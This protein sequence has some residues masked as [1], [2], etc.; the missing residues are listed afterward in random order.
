MSFL[1]GLSQGISQGMLQQKRQSDQEFQQQQERILNAAHDV[2][3]NMRPED[4]GAY[5]ESLDGIIKAKNPKQLH[6]AF[7]A[8]TT[9]IIPEN[10]GKEQQ[11]QDY[12]ESIN[13]APYDTLGDNLGP[14][15][16]GGPQLVLPPNEDA[17][18][19]AKDPNIYAA[20]KIRVRTPEGDMGRQMDAYTQK[21]RINTQNRMEIENAKIRA[22]LDQRK[23]E[24]AAKGLQN[25]KLVQDAETKTA[26]YVGFNPATQKMETHILDG[27]EI[28]A[29][30]LGEARLK[31]Q[32]EQFNQT[33][34]QRQEEFK[35]NVKIKSAEFAEQKRLHNA[36][37]AKL[38]EEV[39]YIKSGAK[40]NSANANT[41]REASQ[42]LSEFQVAN[43]PLFDQ[44]DTLNSEI[45]KMMTD[46][47]GGDISEREANA[48]AI[49]AQR[50]NLVK[51]YDTLYSQVN[52]RIQA[53]RGSMTPATGGGGGGKAPATSSPPSSP[54]SKP[55]LVVGGVKGRYKGL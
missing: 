8:L 51:Q 35:V 23:Q 6:E 27:M 30:V 2:A 14:G 53:L 48:K 40:N 47:F 17:Q 55:P 21:G 15:I 26:A 34:A 25:V 29:N 12:N 1:L 39:N 3:K 54:A 31:Q 46:P 10:Y 49:V 13:H 28:P 22:K 33:M 37:I 24:L 38:N 7:G 20:G 50:D 32:G 11:T 44:I 5:H 19:L 42:V 16:A 36:Q 45:S 43:K 18:P 41:L 4:M 9:K 52:A